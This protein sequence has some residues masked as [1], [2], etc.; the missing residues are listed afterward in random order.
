LNDIVGIKKISNHI[1]K[2]EMEIEEL[3]DDDKIAEQQD[4][5]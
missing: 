1:E 3:K 5:K 4:L 2:I